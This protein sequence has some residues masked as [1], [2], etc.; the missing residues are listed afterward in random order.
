MNITTDFNWLES[1]LDNDILWLDDTLAWDSVSQLMLSNYNLYTFLTS[2]FFVDCYVIYDQ[3]VKQSVLDVMAFNTHNSLRYTLSNASTSG[4][5]IHTTFGLNADNARYEFLWNQIV[6]DSILFLDISHIAFKSFFYTDYQDFFV[7]LLHHSPELVLAFTDFTETTVSPY[8]LNY[9]P[10]VTFDFFRDEL[11]NS[12]SEFVESMATAYLATLALIVFI[13][14]FTT[15]KLTQSND[16]PLVRFQN[17]L[18]ATHK[19]FRVQFEVAIMVFFL[20]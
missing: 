12:I 14:Q 20:P 19:E 15:L 11:N 1:Y 16:A 5:L 9:K 3:K 8:M 17:Y 2:S 4:D 7:M 18:Y 10:H 6:L 13:H